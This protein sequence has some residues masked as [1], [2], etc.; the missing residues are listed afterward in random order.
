MLK[1]DG[2]AVSTAVPLAVGSADGWVDSRAALSV[3]CLAVKRAVV[4][5]DGTV[6]PTV[7]R[8]VASRVLN[9][10]V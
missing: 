10:V 2:T 4:L 7:Q 8:L 3:F 5:V 6:G 9:W 1:A